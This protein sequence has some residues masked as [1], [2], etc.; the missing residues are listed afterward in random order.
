MQSQEL[1]EAEML[2][3]LCLAVE[4]RDSLGLLESE[5]AL[6]QSLE[7]LWVEMLRLPCLA[8]VD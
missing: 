6:A 8:V 2:Q 4:L 3:L 7:L 5:V 1:I